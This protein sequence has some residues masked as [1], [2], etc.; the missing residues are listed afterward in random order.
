[1][2]SYGDD[3]SMRIHTACGVAASLIACIGFS[4][5]YSRRGC[6]VVGIRDMVRGA[7]ALAT[8][9]PHDQ[10]NVAL[11]RIGSAS[12]MLGTVLDMPDPDLMEPTQDRVRVMCAGVPTC[13]VLVDLWDHPSSF[14]RR[15]SCYLKDGASVMAQMVM[16]W[17]IHGSLRI[18]MELDLL[19]GTAS[20][21]EAVCG[22]RIG[23]QE[24]PV[25]V[26]EQRQHQLSPQVPV[27]TPSRM[28]TA[29]ESLDALLL[30]IPEGLDGRH[31]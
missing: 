22:W 17:S 25:F 15:P 27:P 18:Y 19:K 24:G 21:C 12:D 20:F 29:E 26:Q 2:M 14:L 16:K 31:S 9:T 30:F 8:I 23:E 11:D 6:V 28:W 4:V 7:F 3:E 10:L 1:M 5:N 13:C